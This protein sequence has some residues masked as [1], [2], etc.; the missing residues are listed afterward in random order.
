MEHIND[1]DDQPEEPFAQQSQGYE[2]G[3]SEVHDGSDYGQGADQPAAYGEPL[4]EVF[5][6]FDF[7]SSEDQPQPAAET[8]TNNDNLD[9]QSSTASDHEQPGNDAASDATIEIDTFGQRLQLAGAISHR[10]TS[11]G[12]WRHEVLAEIVPVPPQ[13]ELRVVMEQVQTG[14]TLLILE[15]IENPETPTDIDRFADI[16]VNSLSI[17]AGIQALENR[18]PDPEE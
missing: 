6:G 14:I 18:T 2:P 8:A 9:A 5:N 12:L 3:I 15:Q 4:P 10:T 1:H 16:I 11:E 17:T 13:S 7:Q